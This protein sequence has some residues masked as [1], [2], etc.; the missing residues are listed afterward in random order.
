[1][2]AA[3]VTAAMTAMTGA[4]ALWWA[5]VGSSAPWFLQGT[6]VGSA[7][8]AVTPTRIACPS[9]CRHG[10]PVGGSG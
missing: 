4:L 6:R 5:A 9:R 3:T 7:A 10:Q 2:L 8:S 1:M